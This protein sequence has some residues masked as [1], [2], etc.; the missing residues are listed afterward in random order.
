MRI[1]LE[2]LP[3]YAST[4]FTSSTVHQAPLYAIQTKQKQPMIKGFYF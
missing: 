3:W 1:L 2:K 4:G